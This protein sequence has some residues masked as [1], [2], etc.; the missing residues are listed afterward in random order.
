MRASGGHGGP[1]GSE[2]LPRE[3]DRSPGRP[4]AVRDAL[5]RSLAA[6]CVLLVVGALAG[7]PD[8][9]LL[10]A[11][12]VIAGTWALSARPRGHVWVDVVRRMPLAV[13]AAADGAL[14]AGLSVAAPP[15]TVAVRLRIRR[16]GHRSREALVDVPLVRTLTV[17]A[18]SVR[19]GPQ[20]LFEVDHQGLAA[21]GHVAGPAGRTDAETVAVLPPTSSLSG[22]P[23]PVRLRGLTGRHGSRRPGEGGDLRDVHPL[24]PGDPLRQVDWRVTARR[25]PGLQELYVRRSHALAEAMVVL[26]MDSRDDVG[27][28]P[29]TWGGAVPVRPDDP[30]S[31]DIARGAAATVAQ[32]YLGSG[33]RV[34]VED[35]G[36]LRRTVR[37]GAGRRQL[38]RVL[39]QL[40]VLRP[41]GDP[42]HRVRPPKV[43][44]GALVYLFSTFL[45]SEPAEL[46][47]FWRRSGH[48][49]VAVDVLPPIRR[50]GLDPRARLALRIV[51]LRR[52]D[53]L[54][55]VAA[56][57]AEV[58]RW[59]EEDPA[60][61]LQVMLHQW[62]RRPG[63]GAR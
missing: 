58:V 45:D 1:A 9:A 38:D 63:G 4:W 21:A 48:R 59:C 44:S 37:P 12:P 7:R 14:V 54:A 19:T 43:P 35:L 27:P 29:A 24:Q 46:A 5:V 30:T 31:L 60:A 52:R 50:H 8:V 32:A 13:S 36:V 34:G 11:A 3:P 57:G 10:G 26:V 39:Q 33:D 17:T 42:P 56:S 25:S 2:R 6:G 22:L 62:Q 41:A 61:R 55:D 28:D 51:E 18:R 49:V 16:P 15:G 47:R 40:A 53:T 20:D 23:L